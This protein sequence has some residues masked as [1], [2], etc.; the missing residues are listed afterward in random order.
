MN[1]FLVCAGVNNVR[2]EMQAAIR[3]PFR[4][5]GVQPFGAVAGN[6]AE[7]LAGLALATPAYP[8]GCGSLSFTG[9][10]VRTAVFHSVSNCD[11]DSVAGQGT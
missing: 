6:A 3:I 7:L 10:S 9:G 2:S 5:Q 8:V 11:C 4:P 1:I